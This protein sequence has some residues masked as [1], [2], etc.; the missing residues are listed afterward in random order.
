VSYP[1]I[2]KELG[3]YIIGS[4]E[5]AGLVFVML[6]VMILIF[7]VNHQNIPCVAFLE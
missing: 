7:L 2:S 6:I 5:I 1:E 4:L 3:Y